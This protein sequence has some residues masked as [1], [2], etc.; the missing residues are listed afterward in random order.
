MPE[1]ARTEA[2]EAAEREFARLLAEE[3]KADRLGARA[4][5]QACQDSDVDQLMRAVD[6]ITDNTIDGWRLAML[7]VARLPVVSEEI[8]TAFLSIWIESKGLPLRVGS[9]PIMARALHVL[10][11]P[12]ALTEPLTLYRGTTGQER[13][14]RLYGFSWTT[15][16][17]IAAR[18]AEHA[19]RS[20]SGGVILKTVAAPGTVHLRREPEDYY[21]EGEVVVDPYRLGRVEVVRVVP[22]I[23]NPRLIAL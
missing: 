12:V 1:S 21:D 15:D 6:F 16:E 18:F 5:A 10:M 19:R 22:A 9:R 2:P 4:F 20:Q 13:T 23:P 17:E 14:R 3:R 7:K 8:Q 11:P